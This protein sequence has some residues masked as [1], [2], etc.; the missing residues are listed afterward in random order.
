MCLDLK[1]GNSRIKIA[2]EDIVCWKWLRLCK[3]GKLFSPYQN[4]RYYLND[5][6]KDTERVDRRVTSI[7]GVNITHM[8]SCG[9]FHTFKNKE[10]AE[11]F[12]VMNGWLSSCGVV[13]KCI[14]P[15]GSKY[16]EGIFQSFGFET[17]DSYA[18]KELITTVEISPGDKRDNI[19]YI[20]KFMTEAETYKNK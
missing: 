13:V 7:R 4:T 16:Y 3:D 19:S 12:S 11:M 1:K 14:I 18:S 10:D 6:M 5:R 8:L 20:A 17:V 2:Q 15:K 9:C